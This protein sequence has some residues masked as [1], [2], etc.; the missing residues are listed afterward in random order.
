[1]AAAQL[2]NAAAE[3]VED[4]GD[5]GR[6]SSVFGRCPTRPCRRHHCVRRPALRQPALLA[7]H[8]MSSAVPLGPDYRATSSGRHLRG[9]P[10]RL[11]LAAPA[12]L[13]GRRA[14]RVGRP[15]RSRQALIGGQLGACAS[16][17]LLGGIQVPRLS[18]IYARKRFR[19]SILATT[20]V[21][22]GP[23]RSFCAS[24]IGADLA[25]CAMLALA[26][27]A[28]NELRKIAEKQGARNA[29]IKNARCRLL[30]Q[31][32]RNCVFILR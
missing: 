6:G 17:L 3:A 1:M 10:P 18:I 28:R 19:L 29:R 32:K 15:G 23:S 11:R 20:A 4:G 7:H 16:L 5:A 31:Q 30:L 8:R 27:V 25:T 2:Q 9:G 14:H 22:P 13:S 24:I 26:H 21:R 12:I